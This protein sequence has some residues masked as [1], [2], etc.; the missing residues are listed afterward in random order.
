MAKLDEQRV[1][2]AAWD[3]TLKMWNVQTGKCLQT[4]QGHTSSV[5]PVVVKL[6]EQRIVSCSYDKTL[7]VWEPATGQ[8]IATFTAGVLLG[9]CAT[10]NTK[11]MV[12]GDELGRVH[13][14]RL[15]GVEAN[16]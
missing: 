11:L 6:D 14:L 9:A 2:S 13:V 10:V 1:V 12:V 4:L 16:E 7:K 8:C 5:G 15:V 3:Q